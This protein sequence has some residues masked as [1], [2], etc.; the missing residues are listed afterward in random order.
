MLCITFSDA[1][2]RVIEKA[3]I[4]PFADEWI[5]LRR[6]LRKSIEQPAFG[7]HE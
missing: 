5:I 4:C 1:R 3:A 7:F 6:S 2:D